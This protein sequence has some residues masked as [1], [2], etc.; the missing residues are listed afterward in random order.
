MKSQKN[1]YLKTQ[2]LKRIT[3]PTD[4]PVVEVDTVETTEPTMLES[5]GVSQT[6]AATIYVISFWGLIAA[7]VGG[8]IYL[9]AKR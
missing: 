3:V 5:L 8:A 4:I 1:Q 6:T 2:T 9:I 7:A